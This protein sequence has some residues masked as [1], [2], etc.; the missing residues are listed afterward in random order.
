M[1][2]I[3][4][5]NVQEAGSRLPAGGYIC[6]IM[7]VE[8][9]PDNE[10]L[11]ICFDISEGQNAGY[12]NR[13]SQGRDYWPGNFRKYYTAKALPFFKSFLTAVKLSNSHFQYDGQNFNDE[14]SLI[15][16]RVGLVLGYEEYP[17]KDGSAK[18][19]IYV[20]NE[21]SIQSIRDGKFNIPELKKLSSGKP[22]TDN[23]GF[24][25]VTGDEDLP[26]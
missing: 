14:N 11:T 20:A 5:N 3:N 12:F 26:F 8:D 7:S 23:F 19:R 13:L 25:P 24:T 4:L 17:A 9:M 21:Q 2:N 22:K 10:F 18:Q 16:M 6:T 1:K 15:N